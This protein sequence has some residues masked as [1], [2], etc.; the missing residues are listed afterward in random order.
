MLPQK[1][2][3]TELPTELIELICNYLVHPFHDAILDFRLANKILAEKSSHFFGEMYFA[4]NQFTI[5]RMKQSYLVLRQIQQSM[6]V[7]FI[8]EV[9]LSAGDINIPVVPHGMTYQSFYRAKQVDPATF[10]K[11][12]SELPNLKVIILGGFRATCHGVSS[13]LLQEIGPAFVHMMA[14]HL[15]VP[16]LKSLYF[17][18][19]EAARVDVITLIRKHKK[20]LS[21]IYFESLLV[22]QGS[23]T[24][25]IKCLGAV[26][27]LAHVNIANPAVRHASNR[28]DTVS[29][30]PDD[31]TSPDFDEIWGEIDSD[32]SADELLADRIEEMAERDEWA[33]WQVLNLSS[34]PHLTFDHPRSWTCADSERMKDFLA[35][36][37]K[38]CHIE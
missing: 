12:L 20:T 34:D 21:N 9:Q 28:I 36:L 33:D 10:A 2:V 23:W 17:E 26:K 13:T 8:E 18:R 30:A 15:N 32:I 11:V 7:Q 1:T 6:F 19:M 38:R 22:N 16:K 5:A 31:D 37:T 14:E 27:D 4:R 25:I 29:F 24:P 35:A 3:I